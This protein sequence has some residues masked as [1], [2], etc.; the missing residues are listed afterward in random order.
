MAK[1]LI[2]FELNQF[3]WIFLCL[4]VKK[5]YLCD[6]KML[7]RL[8]LLPWLL[9]GCVVDEHSDEDDP[10]VSSIV[11][12]GDL[13]PDFSVEVI[14][15]S[16]RTLFNNRDLEGTTIIVFFHTT[17]VDCQ[18][19]LPELNDYYL[20]HR[21]DPG[22]QMVAIAREESEESIA[23]YWKQHNLSIPYSPQT[24]RRIY[25][26]FATQFIPR[27]YICSAKGIVLWMGVENFDIQE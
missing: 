4:F 14:D 7:I 24:D 22:F 19:E 11:R 23:S 12:V 3:S 16:S 26:L 27:V 17:C 6:V 18:R 15:G 9:V 21:Q 20:R 8:F 13:L 2:F 1:I 25:N 5:H 10:D